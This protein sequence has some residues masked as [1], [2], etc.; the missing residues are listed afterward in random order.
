MNHRSARGR[1]EAERKRAQKPGRSKNVP[2]QVRQ[3]QQVQGT[4][5]MCTSNTE[6]GG[7]TGVRRE[8][9]SSTSD[10]VN[11]V[12]STCA[13]VQHRKLFQDLFYSFRLR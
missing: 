12:G 10:S 13:N 4:A 3:L 9:L 5:L 2:P 6:E 11:I 1:W 8:S 7:A